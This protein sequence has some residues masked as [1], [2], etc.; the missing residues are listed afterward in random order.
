MEMT[1]DS[2]FLQIC[3]E[4][5]SENRP[6]EEW[7]ELESDDQWQTSNYVGGF[8]STEMAFCFEVRRPAGKFWFQLS[9]GEIELIARGTMKYVQLRPAAI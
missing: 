7:A 2:E 4:V 5:V 9:L 1:V 6:L 8:D 3:R